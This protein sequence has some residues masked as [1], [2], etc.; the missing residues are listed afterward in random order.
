MAASP[1][2]IAPITVITPIRRAWSWWLRLT[3]PGSDR[4]VFIKRPLRRLSF[5]HVAHWA[6]FDRLPASAGRRGR[7][8]PTPYVLFQS[9]FDGPAAE[10]A[11]AFALEIPWRIRGLWGGAYRFPGPRPANDFVRYVLKHAIAEPYHYYC[12]YPTATV[13]T[14]GASL[15]LRESF[16][17]FRRETSELEPEEFAAAWRQFLTVEQRN[18]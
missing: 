16:E 11:E 9:N 17:R 1:N 7:R 5:I 8:L 13:R 6:L 4:S 2:Q 15:H 18:L 3:W 10:Y 12:R 14:V